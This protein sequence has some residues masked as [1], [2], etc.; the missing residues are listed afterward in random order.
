MDVGAIRTDVAPNPLVDQPL[1]RRE[2]AERLELVKAVKAVNEGQ[3]FGQNRELTFSFDRTGRRAVVKIVHRE[4]REVIR[5]I[6]A[7]QVLRLAESLDGR[8]G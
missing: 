3:L 5:Q 4:T 6:P 1:S 8:R 2:V 7:E